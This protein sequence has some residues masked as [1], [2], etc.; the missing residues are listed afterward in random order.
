[1][2][3]E[4]LIS[5]VKNTLQKK[6]NIR[7]S[8]SIMNIPKQ[9]FLDKGDLAILLDSR[10]E[11]LSMEWLRDGFYH[12]EM[13]G[14]FDKEIISD[15]LKNKNTRLFEAINFNPIIDTDYVIDYKM[16]APSTKNKIKSSIQNSEEVFEKRFSK[17][18]K[19]VNKQTWLKA[20]KLQNGSFTQWCQERGNDR[21]TH[22]CI[23]EAYKVADSTADHALKRRAAM[24]KCFNKIAEKRIK[25]RLNG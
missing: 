14:E 6:M 25:G 16:L 7:Q 10:N 12:V 17:F 2:K 15:I 3:L 19:G 11:I 24:A 20:L 22:K 23:I 13:K 4:G 8:I 9:K 21:A 1:M 5:N 18:S